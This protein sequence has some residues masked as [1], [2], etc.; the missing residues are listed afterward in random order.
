MRREWKDELGATGGSVRGKGL[1][2]REARG[3]YS[4]SKGLRNDDRLPSLDLEEGLES[5]LF[6][7]D[8]GFVSD[9]LRASSDEASLGAGLEQTKKKER[10][11]VGEQEKKRERESRTHLGASH[12]RAVVSSDATHGTLNGSHVVRTGEDETLLGVGLIEGRGSESA[13]GGGE[14]REEVENVPWRR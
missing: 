3:G 6:V 1:L 5:S 11:S 8:L 10:Q 7:L 9:V 2:Y 14:L 13:R 12:V 4:T